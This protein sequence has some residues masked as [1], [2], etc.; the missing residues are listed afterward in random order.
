MYLHLTMLDKATL[1]EIILDLSL[2]IW[3]A[4]LPYN[5]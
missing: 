2:L 1:N 3:V 5:K 4:I